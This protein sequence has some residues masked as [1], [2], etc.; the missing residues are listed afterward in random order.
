MKTGYTEEDAIA[1][2][3]MLA[4]RCAKTLKKLKPLMARRKI[5]AFRLYDWDIP[6]VRAIVDWYQGHIVVS[7]YERTQTETVKDWLGTVAAA[8]AQKLGL[9]PEQVHIRRRHTGT[10]TRYEKLSKGGVRLA[11]REGDLQFMVNLDTYLDTGLFADHRLTRELVMKEARGKRFLNLFCYTGSF[12]C[13]A[14]K[15]GARATTSVDA[16]NTYLEWAR[17][18]FELNGMNHS[19]HEVAKDDVLEFLYF[20][21]A[22]EQFYDLC[23]VDPPSFSIGRG[24]E[25]FDVQRDHVNMLQAVVKLMNPGGVIYFSTN[26]QRFEPH[27]DE[28]QGISEWQDITKSTIDV[29]YRNDKVHQCYRLVTNA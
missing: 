6:E 26:H 10:G 24:R 20:E 16:S 19:K 2:G 9:T 5:E 22:R 11:V 3:V 28:V 7:E 18:N 25:S 15:G 14:A 21:R 13:Y 17:E 1:H 29:D 12:T 23:V 8:T 27:L 4:N